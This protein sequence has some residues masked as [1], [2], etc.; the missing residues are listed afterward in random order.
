MGTCRGGKKC[1]GG[2]M[3]RNCRLFCVGNIQNKSE[4]VPVSVSVV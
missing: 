1:I 2:N 4:W 3:G